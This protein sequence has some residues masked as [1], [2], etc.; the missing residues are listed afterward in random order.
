M[1]HSRLIDWLFT[2]LRPAQE[3]FTYMETSPLPVKGCRILAYAR[4]SGPL[5]REVSLSCHTC[6]DT[7]PRF[8]RS[9]P[10]DRPIQSPLMTHEGVWRIYSNPDPH[11]TFHSRGGLKTSLSL[12]RTQEVHLR[13]DCL[14]FQVYRRLNWCCLFTNYIIC[15]ADY[16]MFANRQHRFYLR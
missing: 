14:N 8:F 6:S 5:G 2:V 13:N 1:F 7:G 15:V 10:K 9:L 4:R 12:K 3:F 11:G 16:I